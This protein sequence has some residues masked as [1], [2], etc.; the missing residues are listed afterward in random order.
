MTD[1]TTSIAYTHTVL[2]L[3]NELEIKVIGG[4]SGRGVTPDTFSV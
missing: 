3:S 2:E 4:N 1:N